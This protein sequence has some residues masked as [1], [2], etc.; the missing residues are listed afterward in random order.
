[1]KSWKGALILLSLALLSIG[2]LTNDYD[3]LLVRG[4]LPFEWAL[5]L[6]YSQKHEIP[7]LTTPPDRLEE[8]ILEELQ[9]YQSFG[10]TRVLII[11]GEEAIS[12]EVQRELE[13]MG[14]L[15]HRISEADRYGTS[16]RVA[17]ELYPD[18]SG[19]ILVSGEDQGTTSR[20]VA[21]RFASATGYPILFLREDEIPLSVSDSLAALRPGKL[22]LIGN[23]SQGL[24]ESLLAAGYSVTKIQR[25]AEVE[26]GLPPLREPLF[27]LGGV[28][29][30]ILLVLSYRQLFGSREK[31]PF[32]LLTPDEE[33]IVR[34]LSESGGVITQDQLPEKTGFSRP[35]VSRIV[36]DLS[37]RE[38]IK[39]EPEGRTQKL[40]L[41]KEFYEMR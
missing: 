24:E 41:K 10:Y 36:S 18:A 22:Y 38:I 5:S 19:A 13:E 29:L 34:A 40:I 20:L 8:T 23:V 3:L 28:L 27:F 37:E 9:G 2:V 14:F 21:A 6:A 35:K 39:K 16:A 7:I 11:G 17:V 15:T 12:L 31:I 32:T 1:M 4:D 30:G 25:A 26:E 33:K